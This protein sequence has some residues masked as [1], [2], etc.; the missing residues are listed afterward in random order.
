MFHLHTANRLDLLAGALTELL[1]VRPGGDPFAEV[2]VTVAHPGMGRWLELRLAES[3]GVAM[4][5]AWPLPGRT[6]WDLLRAVGEPVPDEDPM[7]RE[8]LALRLWSGLRAGTL[9][10]PGDLLSGHDGEG[11]RAWRIA[12]ALAEALD[13]YPLYRPDWVRDWDAGRP[14]FGGD[15]DL[16]ARYGWQ[17]ALWRALTRGGAH[18]LQYID[19]LLARLAAGRPPEGLPERVILFG[20]SHLPPLYL[21]LFVALGAACEVHLFMLTPSQEWWGD[22]PSRREAR[23]RLL[24]GHD[25][26][27]PLLAQWGR[28]SRDFIDLLYERLDAVPHQ[29]HEH[30]ASPGGTHTLARLQR[31][32]LRLESSAPF[33]PD[34]SLVVHA[35]HGPM[36]ACQEAVEAILAARRADPTL[37]PREIAVLCVDIDR[38]APYL[39][40]AFEALPPEA[41]LPYAIVDRR[42]DR[43][44]PLLATVTE[45]LRL[46]QLRVT[47][48]WVR[49]LLDQP[50]IRRRFGI[51]GAQLPALSR[52]LQRNGVRWGLDESDRSVQGFA[53]PDR[54]SLAFGEARALA[55][56]ALPEDEDLVFEGIAPAEGVEGDLTPA[57]G[58][59][60]ALTERLRHWRRRMHAERRLGDWCRLTA[61]LV[62]DFTQ[63]DAAGLD[64]LQPLHDALAAL[65]QDA[66]LLRLDEP[67][68]APLFRSLL[69]ARI[70]T[71]RA[72][73]GY[74]AGSITCCALQPLR[75][76]PFRHIQVL[77][78]N[79]RDFPR[80]DRRSALDAL[81]A[82]VRRGDRSP[83]D[84]DRLMLLETL[85]AAGEALHLHYHHRDPRDD[86]QLQPAG[87]V[88]ELLEVLDEQP[89]S[90]EASPFV[91]VHPMQPFSP[92]RYTGP[93]AAADPFWY[94]MASGL[95]RPQRQ[96]A[97]PLGD[98][99]A[100]PPAGLE[101]T[102]ELGDLERF[103]CTPLAWF[104]ERGLGLPRAL[105]LPVLD[106]HERFSVQGLDGYEIRARLA[107]A[108]EEGRS[109][110]GEQLATRLR[111]E[112]L[113]PEGPSGEAA[114]REQ[115]GQWA[116]M[117]RRLQRYQGRRLEPVPVRIPFEAAGQGWVLEGWLRH[118]FAADSGCR[119]LQLRPG[120]PRP[121]DWLRLWVETLAACA[122]ALAPV[123]GRTVARRGDPVLHPL[124]SDQARDQLRQLAALAVE[125]LARP[126]PLAPEAVLAWL[127]AKPEERESAVRRN[128]HQWNR[129]HERWTWAEQEHFHRI[130]GEV[131]DP[132]EIPGFRE[133]VERVAS[134]LGASLPVGP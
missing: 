96:P 129:A 80:R 109:V 13:Q 34:A 123:E 90:P 36:R 64:Q 115:A 102:L 53:G 42:A 83:R 76:L 128:W 104:L 48:A 114:W 84:D 61:E 49:G 29:T 11:L 57:L 69:G 40:A 26:V 112:G 6:V 59:L 94:A 45:L 2:A 8:R 133:Q 22:A 131:A 25:V 127:Q 89:P 88:V 37:A 113:L 87:P 39:E 82:H 70:A 55:G 30:F 50:A 10:V 125:G 31:D 116:R 81:T 105:E 65:E 103:L 63:P 62:A 20:P 122:C 118:I 52:W 93:E 5:L 32:L 134:L 111:A 100:A 17:A 54:H 4:R 73:E 126:L 99:P 121:K 92:M 60:F 44:L 1:R 23:R 91:R 98:T 3:L 58:G 21:D 35:T 132:L 106:E 74:L 9:P 27:H 41:R 97:P 67:L 66:A 119:V 24:T 130:W 95:E 107:R 15:P 124:P 19:R 79:E 72:T 78:L 77:G 47:A 56:Y 28:E 14:G 16:L 43:E 33:T 7:A 101:P 108:Y 46:P 110:T 71:P 12:Q 85:L 68:P 18:R 51:D 117:L 38:Y 75:N 86:S 120:E